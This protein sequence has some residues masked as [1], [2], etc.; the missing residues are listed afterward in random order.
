MEK[1]LI[2]TFQSFTNDMKRELKALKQSPQLL[3]AI[4]LAEEYRKLCTEIGN[5]RNKYHGLYDFINIVRK[6]DTLWRISKIYDVS[7]NLLLN[8]NRK[9]KRSTIKPGEKIIIPAID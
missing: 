6:G 7:L 8:S 3:N 2:R 5:Q 4:R 1:E 9:S